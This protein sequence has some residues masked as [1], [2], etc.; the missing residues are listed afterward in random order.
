MKKSHEQNAKKGRDQEAEPKS[1][2][3]NNGPPKRKRKR[4]NNSVSRDNM[5]NTTASES[6]QSN[7][8]AAQESRQTE[9]AAVQQFR[10]TEDA[11]AQQS[12]QSNNAKSS[13][14]NVV[15]AN[16]NDYNSRN[17]FPNENPGNEETGQ[18]T[19]GNK[20]STSISGVVASG[21]SRFVSKHLFIILHEVSK[22]QPV[23][24]LPV[25]STVNNLLPF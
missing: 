17:K 10:Q 21:N 7:K 8:A 14:S 22:A 18:L 15:L 9:D 5:P 11:P 2:P 19:N 20:P 4:S 1:G 6:Q 3:S 23:L 24:C 16:G 25:L 13:S 12:P